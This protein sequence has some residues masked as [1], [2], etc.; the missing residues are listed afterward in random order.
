MPIIKRRSRDGGI[1]W[2]VRRSVDGKRVFRAFGTGADAKTAAEKYERELAGNL[3]AARIGTDNR[4]HT[5]G[6][7]IEATRASITSRLRDSSVRTYKAR[8]NALID[9]YGHLRLNSITNKFGLEVQ[10]DLS[11]QGHGPKTTNDYLQLLNRIMEHAVESG[12]LQVNPLGRLKRLREPDPFS[13]WREIPLPTIWTIINSIKYNQ[14]F[15]DALIALAFTGMRRSDLRGVR[16]EDIQEDRIRI[17]PH[18]LRQLKAA[19][20][21][22]VVPL[23]EIL[24]PILDKHRSWGGN[25]PSVKRTGR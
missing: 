17:V 6:D 14:W 21:A 3:R 18:A 23:P 1:L 7:A 24:I 5:I 15:Q 2:C 20:S 19:G 11:R 9:S 16:W 12:W 8:L 22:R 25:G 13:T 4:E 10:Q